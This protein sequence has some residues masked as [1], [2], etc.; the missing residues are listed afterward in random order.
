MCFSKLSVLWLKKCHRQQPLRSTINMLLWHLDVKSRWLSDIQTV[1]VLISCHAECL[2]SAVSVKQV[3][4][5]VFA[6]LLFLVLS[7]I[8]APLF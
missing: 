8:Y 4:I 5:A 1:F 3:N 7:H 2:E 6:V